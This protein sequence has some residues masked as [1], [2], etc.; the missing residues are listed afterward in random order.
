MEKSMKSNVVV[1]HS[2]YGA[3]K[4]YATH[5]AKE[6]GCQALKISSKLKLDDYEQVIIGAPIY[7]GS[8]AGIKKLKLNSQEVYLFLVGLSHPVN[9]LDIFEGVVDKLDPSIKEKLNET[10]FLSGSMDLNKLNF[11]HRQIMK[12]VSK[13]QEGGDLSKPINNIDFDLT[14]AFIKKIKNSG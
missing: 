8:A 12:M 5:I 14:K 9:N 7:A 2:K 1:Y 3:T 10:L 6:L 4:E 11:I 13:S